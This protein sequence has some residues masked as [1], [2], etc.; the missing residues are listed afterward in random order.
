LGKELSKDETLMFYWI[1]EASNMRLDIKK[2]E[3]DAIIEAK[4]IPSK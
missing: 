4:N 3:L 1:I 2:E